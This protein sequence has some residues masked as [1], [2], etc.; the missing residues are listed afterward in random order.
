MSGDF[1]GQDSWK[2]DSA[3]ARLDAPKKGD[4]VELKSHGSGVEGAASHTG[5]G[6]LLAR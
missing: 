2:Q 4:D 6:L 3:D 1:E 5:G